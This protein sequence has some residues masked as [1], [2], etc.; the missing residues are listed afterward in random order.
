MSKKYVLDAE[1]VVEE[2]KDIHEYLVKNIEYI[3]TIK[4]CIILLDKAIVELRTNQC[5]CCCKCRG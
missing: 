2:F 5:K 4:E 1:K 3:A